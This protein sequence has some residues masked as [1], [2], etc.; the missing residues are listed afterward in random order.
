MFRT[1]ACRHVET[2]LRAH[3]TV[4][5]DRQRRALARWVTGAQFVAAAIHAGDYH[6]G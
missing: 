6:L 2:M 4:L 3:L 5:N 1:A